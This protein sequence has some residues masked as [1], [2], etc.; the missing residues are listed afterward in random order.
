[1]QRTGKF[2]EMGLDFDEVDSLLPSEDPLRGVPLTFWDSWLD[3]RNHSFRGFYK[4][5]GKEDWPV[6]A[7]LIAKSLENDSLISDPRILK[8]FDLRRR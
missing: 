2:S 1:M 5:I 6:L 8:A 3:E 7:E 4:E